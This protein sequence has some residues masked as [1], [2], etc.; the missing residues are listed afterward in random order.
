MTK[1]GIGMLIVI[2]IAGG[3]LIVFAAILVTR[4]RA[5]LL[6]EDDRW[7]SYEEARTQ[8]GRYA[9]GDPTRARELDQ[10]AA[11]LVLAELSKAEA[12]LHRTLP[13][14]VRGHSMSLSALAWRTAQRNSMLERSRSALAS[15]LSHAEPPK[16]AA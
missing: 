11:L 5:P 12:T 16:E 10:L 7:M 3:M 15:Y 13:P 9:K 6:G 14:H 8:L 2:G 4:Y 1:R